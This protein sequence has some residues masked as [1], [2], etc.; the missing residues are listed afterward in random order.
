ML[1][2]D[3]QKTKAVDH[4][5]YLHQKQTHK[6]KNPGSIEILDETP[7]RFRPSNQEGNVLDLFEEF[8]QEIEAS[9]RNEAPNARTRLPGDAKHVR[10]TIEAVDNGDRLTPAEC[11]DVWKYWYDMRFQHPLLYDLAKTVFAVAPTE[12]SVERNFST[13]DFI[14]NKKRASLHDENLEMILFL[15]LNHSL[16]HYPDCL[17]QLHFD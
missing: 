6:K 5:L 12:V 2:S 15:K 1:L 16:F 10:E 11:P 9:K 4:L 13:L 3:N 17:A 7:E 8:L 14:L